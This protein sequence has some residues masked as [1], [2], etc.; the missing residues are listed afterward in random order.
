MK[1][2]LL[3]ITGIILLSGIF[4]ITPTFASFTDS[5]LVQVSGDLKK[6]YYNEYE[7]DFVS[8]DPYSTSVLFETKGNEILEIKV[9]KIY[10]EG[11]GIFIL[12][13]GEEIAPVTETSDDCFYYFNIESKVRETIEVAFVGWPETKK[14]KGCETFTV[15]PLQ[16]FKLGIPT[17]EIQCRESLIMVTKQ[18]GSPACVKEQT[19]QKLIERGWALDKSNISQIAD[20]LKQ[21]PRIIDP[22]YVR[23]VETLA[24]EDPI[25]ANFVR[26]EDWESQC[27]TYTARNNV[28]ELNVKFIDIANKNFL[29]ITFD[30]AT[31]KIINIDTIGMNRMGVGLS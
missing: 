1:T 16:G 18:D 22:E 31:L 27:C 8:F 7:V 29:R 4:L 19:R 5:I 25:V 28:D 10:Q 15:F 17:D 30:L 9:P 3:I 11:P 26:G 13:N 12:K 24:L 14:V 23:Y 21:K 2:R 6:V 20:Y